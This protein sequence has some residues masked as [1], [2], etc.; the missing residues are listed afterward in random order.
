MHFCSFTCSIA[1]KFCVSGDTHLPVWWDLALRI[2]FGI[3][4][5]YHTIQTIV[6][7]S[8][9]FTNL[10]LLLSNSRLNVSSTLSSHYFWAAFNLIFF[11]DHTRAWQAPSP[12]K[13]VYKVTRFSYTCVRRNHQ[14]LRHRGSTNHVSR[15]SIWLCVVI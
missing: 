6:G 14:K 1:Q 10:L 9:L 4:I 12:C 8:G 5:L 11:V 2:F 13:T 7:S 3:Y 15:L